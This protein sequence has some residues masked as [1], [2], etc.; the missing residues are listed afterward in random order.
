MHHI[1]FHS[2]FAAFKYSSRLRASKLT[3]ITD[4]I[5]STQASISGYLS[6]RPRKP[7]TRTGSNTRIRHIDLL[8]TSVFF[9]GFVYSRIILSGFPSVRNV[10]WLLVSDC[11]RFLIVRGFAVDWL[12]C[13]RW[14]RCHTKTCFQ[15]DMLM[16]W[17]SRLRIFSLIFSHL[18]G[19]KH[20][21]PVVYIG[22]TSDN[23]SQNATSLIILVTILNIA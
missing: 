23:S 2:L 20:E 7:S 14:Q 1:E 12:W 6:F 13:N 18:S 9:W 4:V 3:S 10:N 5:R 11:L 19:H 22:L 16:S 17:C 21:S 8:T 15:K